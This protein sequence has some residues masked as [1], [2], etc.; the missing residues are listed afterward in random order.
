MAF[1]DKSPLKVTWDQLRDAVTAADAAYDLYPRLD[2]T[3][4]TPVNLRTLDGGSIP[5]KN[6]APDGRTFVSEDGRGAAVLLQKGVGANKDYIL[7]FRGTDFD[8]LGYPSKSD[9]V[10]YIDTW[11][12]S[13]IKEFR[14]LLRAVD[15]H[16]DKRPGDLTITGHSMGG[17]IVNRLKA[18]FG[19]FNGDPTIWGKAAYIAFE[20][21]LLNPKVFNLGFQNDPVYKL[22]SP[23][24][25]GAGSDRIWIDNGPMLF[26]S[27]AMT[28]VLETMDRLEFA[29][30]TNLIDFK[31]NI[32]IRTSNARGSFL[33]DAAVGLINYDP[34]RETIY[35]GSSK[36][37]DFTLR[38]Q[39]NTTTY[40]S[41]G[42]GADKV[43]S[44]FNKRDVVVGK[45]GADTVN[46][47]AGD[48]VVSG[49]G[50]IY[51]YQH[52]TLDFGHISAP[53][54]P[55]AYADWYNTSATSHLTADWAL[56]AAGWFDGALRPGYRDTRG[57]ADRVFGAGGND[58][59]YGGAGNDL[60]NG[61][62]HSDLL[63]GSAGSDTLLGGAGNDVLNGGAGADRL[64]GGANLDIYLVDPSDT[65]VEV[66]GGGFDI[67]AASKN[68]TYRL[69]NVESFALS[70][71]ADHAVV[72]I[73]DLDL[74]ALADHEFTITSRS[75][76]TRIE[77]ENNS[78]KGIEYRIDASNNVGLEQ[79]EFVFTSPLIKGT[80]I[81]DIRPNKMS[82]DITATGIRA[83]LMGK[84]LDYTKG[85]PVADGLYLMDNM[86]KIRHIRSD[87]E[88][89]VKEWW[90]YDRWQ[91]DIFDDEFG[92]GISVVQANGGVFD[93]IAIIYLGNDELI[94]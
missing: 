33:Q 71:K 31:D 50:N 84:I 29:T 10:G 49:D 74:A 17:W 88:I 62:S 80:I 38:L 1:L 85:S 28:G 54:N 92:S 20:S 19:K 93:T 9:I 51:N 48:D 4:W 18:D 24:S 13:Y 6:I 65:V 60:L 25:V 43:N 76:G 57:S 78:G 73:E 58:I 11:R 35:I 90:S 87:G 37:D 56:Q 15:D 55:E 70:H 36:N 68:G 39:S 32:F 81:S 8:E 91:R 66:D 22:L 3:G 14:T 52:V 47:G 44:L 26:D 59:L 7:A 16:I 5:R 67:F 53:G 41:L 94:F 69:N 2:K 64:V 30:L 72:K 21:P 86:V 46:A 34:N 40:V 63:L 79:D 82:V 42:P 12:G 23:L 77:I 75:S 45:E 27:H 61:G 89:E 83:D